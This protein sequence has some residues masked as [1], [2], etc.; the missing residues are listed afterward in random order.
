[1]ATIV[2][3]VDL[4]EMLMLFNQG[5][6]TDPV[7]MMNAPLLDAVDCLSNKLNGCLCGGRD[8]CSG[9]PLGQQ[10][11]PKCSI[12]LSCDCIFLNDDMSV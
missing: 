1:M 12:P 2:A 6:K 11:R 5:H 10:S 7:G 4:N 9:S 3:P 8:F